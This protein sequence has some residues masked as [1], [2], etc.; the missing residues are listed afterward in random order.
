MMTEQE[1]ADCIERHTA[2][3]LQDMLFTEF[4]WVLTRRQYPRLESEKSRH[5]R[6][7]L[8]GLILQT[9]EEL[10]GRQHAFGPYE[11]R[12]LA[13]QRIARFKL[14]WPNEISAATDHSR[15]SVGREG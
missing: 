1:Q 6:G 15:Q 13:F 11:I 8:M 3:P 9:R 10:G 2:M 5:R 12:H 14:E 4:D 7:F